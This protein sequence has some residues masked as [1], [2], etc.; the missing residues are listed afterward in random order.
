MIDI[1]DGLVGDLRHVAEASGVALD[2]STEALSADRAALAA[3]ADA[4][5]VD[6]WDWVLGGGEDH[7]LVAAFAG[8]VPQGWRVIGRVLDGPA[9]VLVDGAQWRGHAGWQS[10]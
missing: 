5:G 2:L 10:F 7:A 1:S 4:L 8:P 3:V 9:D 6:P